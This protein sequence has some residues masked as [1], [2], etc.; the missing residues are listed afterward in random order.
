LALLEVK[1]R[2]EEHRF[3]GAL[4]GKHKCCGTMDD[5]PLRS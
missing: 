2:N 1:R 4:K 5:C 3:W